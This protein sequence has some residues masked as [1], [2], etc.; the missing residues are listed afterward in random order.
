M[1]E[2]GKH[3]DLT[4]KD[5]SGLDTEYHGCLVTETEGPLIKMKQSLAPEVI[6]NTASLNFIKAVPSRRKD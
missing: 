4:I 2:V 5:E 6:V 1:F 3:Y